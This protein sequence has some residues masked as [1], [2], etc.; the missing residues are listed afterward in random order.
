[1]FTPGKFARAAPLKSGKCEELDQFGNPGI[2]LGGARPPKTVGD[3]LRN[4]QMREQ[5]VILR[6]ETNIALLWRESQ[7][8]VVVE[9]GFN[10]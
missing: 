3:I 1:L 4:V 5:R 9:P 8:L 10:A 6:E 7:G 2:A